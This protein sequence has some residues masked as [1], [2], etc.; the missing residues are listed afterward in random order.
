[1]PSLKRIFLTASVLL[2]S[3]IAIVIGGV[4]WLS[5]PVDS[6]GEH[7]VEIERGTST[8]AIANQL[9]REGLVRSPW[10]FLLARVAHPRARL[11]AGEYEYNGSYSVW[12]IFDK[13]RLGQVFYREITVPEGSNVFDIAALLQQLDTVA[14]DAFLLAA[15]DAS[16][17]RD[18]DP[19]A[20]TLE[21]Y[22]FPSTYRVTRKSTAKE[23]C[24]QMTS[25]FRRQ[26]AALQTPGAVRPDVH[27]I[28]TLASLVEKE[29]AVP[30]ER[31][32]VAA[33]F[34]NRLRLHMP[35]QCDPTTV[36]AALLE[37]RY[38]GV[39]HKSDLASV[40]PYNTYAHAGLPPGPIANPGALALKAALQPATSGVLYFVARGDGSGHHHFSQTLAEHQ[41]AVASFRKRQP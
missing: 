36:Y 14:P 25:E 38:R 28:V 39:I 22:L 12:Q 2:G 10:A 19:S 24:R 21:G 17:I 16:S 34:F 5:A 29:T 26:W 23:L 7:F 9:A 40:N 37:N 15:K 32:L 1:M 18:L 3:A 33:V 20:P 4:V 6:G 27:R 41:S 8:R 13:I 31:S 11:Q 35:L 30:Q